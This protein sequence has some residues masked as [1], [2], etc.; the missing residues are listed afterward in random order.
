MAAPA[1]T[2][3]VFPAG[4]KMDDGFPTTIAFAR[5]PDVSLWE[6]TVKPPGIDGGDPVDTNTMHNVAWRTKSPR[7]LK[8]MTEST[9]T[10]A[11][12]PK[13]IT[14]IVELVNMEGSITVHYPDGSTLSFYGY[15]Q[16]FEPSDMKEG[17]QPEASVTIVTT[18]QDPVTGSEEPP[19]L[20]EVSGT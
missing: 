12:D 6:K 7:K 8:T 4:I 3:R 13:V 18:N 16:K 5:D 11:Y 19:V 15:L 9:I 10:A 14:Q 2:A 1:L 20:V 17:E